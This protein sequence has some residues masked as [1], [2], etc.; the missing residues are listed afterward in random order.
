MKGIT[1]RGMVAKLLSLSLSLFYLAAEPAQ[2]QSSRSSS[3]NS[4]AGIRVTPTAV[5]SATAESQEHLLY[6]NSCVAPIYESL[7]RGVP[8]T[9]ACEREWD[10]G[11]YVCRHFAR[12]FCKA[13]L[14]N[15]SNKAMG[16]G[17]WAL[18][19]QPA[20][21]VV[22]PAGLLPKMKELWKELPIK[23]MNCAFASCEKELGITNPLRR[24]SKWI[25]CPSKLSTCVHEFIIWGHVINI[26]RSGG[27]EFLDRYGEVSFM[28]VEP[29]EDGGSAVLC[30]WTQKTLEPTI[31]EDCKKTIQ[32]RYFP[33]QFACGLR[34]DFEVVGHA[35]WSA[36]QP[37]I[38]ER[39]G[40]E[41]SKP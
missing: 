36:R 5:P 41:T 13:I 18:L 22:T 34:Y 29:Q 25:S 20:E 33:K 15:G 35:D 30:S 6:Y 10:Y 38:D 9:G 1:L 40:W 16:S 14:D 21:R 28:V 8:Y 32:E 7:S 26:F 27:Q 19:I 12:D 4:A 31:P 11:K 37:V 23:V 2:A 3:T 24:A 17:C 39:L